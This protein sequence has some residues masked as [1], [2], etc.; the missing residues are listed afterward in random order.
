VR[1]CSERLKKVVDQAYV[2][3]Y[4]APGSVKY[5]LDLGRVMSRATTMELVLLTRPSER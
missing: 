3:N 4:N 2:L 1:T 5:A